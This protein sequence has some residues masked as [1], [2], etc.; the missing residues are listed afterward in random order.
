MLRG[1]ILVTIVGFAGCATQ[2]QVIGPYSTRLSEPDIQQITSLITPSEG[3]SHLYTRLEAVR[4]DEV[5]VKYG[6]YRRSAEGV[7]T[8]D[9]AAA[10]FTAYKRGG[11]WVAGSDFEFESRITVY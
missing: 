8:S 2:L 1:L 10:Y 3:A 5:R 11:K 6:G 7:Y 4:P 9:T